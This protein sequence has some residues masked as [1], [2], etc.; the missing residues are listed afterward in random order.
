M[1]LGTKNDSGQCKV[2]QKCREKGQE[3]RTQAIILVHPLSRAIPSLSCNIS[4][5]NCTNQY[6]T[7][8]L[9]LTHDSHTPQEPRTPL[10]WRTSTLQFPQ[11]TKIKC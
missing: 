7:V 5:K 9:Q 4:K 8:Q 2:N 11:F 6:L 3:R 1:D 10:N